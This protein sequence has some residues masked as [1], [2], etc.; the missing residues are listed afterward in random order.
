MNK[1]YKI[2]ETKFG[3]LI[4][5]LLSGCA[6]FIIILSTILSTTQAGGLLGF[7]FFPAIICGT[8]LV[9]LKTIKKLY[10]E[11][12]Y[13]KINIIFYTHILLILISIVFLFDIIMN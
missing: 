9:L 11:E 2:F 10:D 8:A 1:A 3:G 4:F 13:Q 12:Q 6:Y 7:F 5:S